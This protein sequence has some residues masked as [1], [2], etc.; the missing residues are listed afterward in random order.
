VGTVGLQHQPYPWDGGYRCERCF[1]RVEGAWNDASA[2]E[3]KAVEPWAIALSHPAGYGERNHLNCVRCG[4]LLP[5]SAEA[6]EPIAT[7]IFRTDAGSVTL[8]ISASYARL[9]IEC[10]PPCSGLGTG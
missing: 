4:D 10:S 2:C 6:G 8:L 3:V 1:E 5:A 7:T 9:R